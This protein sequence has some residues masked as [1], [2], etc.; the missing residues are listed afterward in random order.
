MGFPNDSWEKIYKLEEWMRSDNNPLDECHFV[1]LTI[2][3]KQ[4]HN[5]RHIFVSSI[6]KNYEQLGYKF[7]E[8]NGEPSWYNHKS[9]LYESDLMQYQYKVNPGL[10][11]DFK[12]TGFRLMDMINMGIDKQDLMTM[13]KREISEKYDLDAIKKQVSLNYYRNLLKYKPK[14]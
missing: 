3:H 1:T 8:R 6:D 5:N 10:I 9:G 12:Y 2:T 4:F 13:S 7:T 11:Q 14:K